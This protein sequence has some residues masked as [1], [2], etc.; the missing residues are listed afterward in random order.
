[1]KKYKEAAPVEVSALKRRTIRS[2]A[3]GQITDSSCQYITLRLDEIAA[4]IEEEV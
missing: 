2:L 1:M 4:H 3:M